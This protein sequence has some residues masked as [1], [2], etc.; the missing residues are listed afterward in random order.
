[1][2]FL[3]RSKLTAANIFTSNELSTMHGGVS[4]SGPGLVVEKF[5]SRM[6]E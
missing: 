4:N 3:T 2:A 6:K 1:M 5:E